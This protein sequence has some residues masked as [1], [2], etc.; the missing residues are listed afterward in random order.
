MIRRRARRR[1]GVRSWLRRVAVGF[2]VLLLI[3]LGGVWLAIESAEPRTEGTVTLAGVGAPVS[4]VRDRYGIPRIGA[5]TERDAYF[6]LGFVHAQ[7]RFFQ[8]EFM[9]RL[10]AGRLSEIVGEPTL[11]VDRW[12]RVLGLYRLAEASLER[13]SPP[14][15]ESLEA[16]AAG[17]NAYLDSHSGLVSVELAL[18]FATPEKWRPADSLVWARLMGMR[19]SAN[20]RAETLR[21]RLSALLPAE[22]IDELWPDIPGG[23]PPTIAAL[24]G[25][26]LFSTLLTDWPEAIAPVTASNIWAVAG[27]QTETGSPILANDPHLGFR[28]P[29]LW[30]L[31]RIETP[32]LTLAG[33]TVPG[34]PMTILGHN[35][36]VAWGLTTT[37]GDTQDLFVER[38]DP[39]DRD[40][41]LTPDGPRPFGRRVE[42]IGVRGR[43]DVTLVVR[44]TR[45]GPVIS[46][47]DPKSASIAK[48]GHVVALAAA[49]LREDDTTGEAVWRLNRARSWEQFDAA[50][51]FFHAPQQNVVYADTA[52]NIGIV[53]AG[54]MPIRRAGDGRY[55]VPGWTGEHDWTGYIPHE[56][57]PRLLNPADGRIVN[58]NHPVVGPDY[59]YR[60]GHGDTPPYRANRIH[61]LL[62][63]GGS[64]TPAA[65]GAMQNDAVSLAARDLLPPMLRAVEDTT[66]RSPVLARLRGWDGTMDRRRP[67]PLVFV[68]WLRA[69]NRLLYADE[70]GAVFP[71]LWSLRPAFVRETLKRETVWCD[72]IA[73]PP[74]EV[75]RET[76]G[77]A[78]DAALS[79]LTARY[80]DDPAKWRW[81]DAHYA[82]FRHG[83]FGWIPLLNRLADIRIPVDG[84]AFTVNRG[85]HRSSRSNAPYASVHGAGYRA[86][87]DL[88][89]LDRSLFIQAT[90]QSGHLT[91][92]H[93]RDLT[94]LWRDGIFLTLGPLAP[95]SPDA[96]ARLTLVPH[97]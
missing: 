64:R 92:P 90:G 10:G 56:D 27:S 22:R 43:E 23:A 54:R 85:Q 34:V 53:V 80:G 37:D 11:R 86:V 70:T 21:A 15:V 61:A 63:A 17:I 14:V 9:R 49:A 46:D 5:E 66:A 84:G 94:P 26:S 39:D 62:D 81:G 40:R 74:R 96:A 91:S 20:S 76:V 28:A 87:Y 72:D 57:L 69:L 75:C 30:Y 47:V 31:A 2:V 88:S 42:R 89:D 24:G 36:F 82:H 97:R 77:K 6:A 41:Y 58:A 68:A 3:V 35:G 29:G 50:L 18:T 60:I 32:D 83:L 65:A 59:P 4:I 67:E 1:R 48:T 55:P 16:Y 8:M 93:Y 44:S 79:E 19:L 78:L 33:A 73:T 71:D 7:D 52:G 45:H 38:L 51:S 25:A 13:L 12:M 95:D